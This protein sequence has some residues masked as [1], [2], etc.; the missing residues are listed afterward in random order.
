M[1]ADFQPRLLQ[2][3]VDFGLVLAGLYF[4]L[5]PPSVSQG[6]AFRWLGVILLGRAVFI[7]AGFYADDGPL[8]MPASIL[9]VFAWTLASL[10]LIGIIEFPYALFRRPVPLALRCVEC[11]F[12]M[13]AAPVP[14]PYSALIIR[15]N[16]L[17][18]PAIVSIALAGAELRKR[19]VDAGVTFLL[20]AIMGA[21][22]LNNILAITF[23]TVYHV[24]W[25]TTV[26][27]AGFRLLFWDLVLLVW[28]P[29]IAM[30]IH[31]ANLH[32]RD[33][34]ERLRREMEAARHV[35]HLLLPSQSI[36]V[37]G[38]EIEASYQPATEVG[39]DFFQILP[40][41]PAS[42]L[43]IMGDV[44]GKGMQAALLVSMVVG[45][46]RNRQSDRPSCVLQELNAVLLG[47]SEG[48]FTTC[49]CALFAPDGTVTLANAGHFAPYRNGEEVATPP[50]LPLGL[51]PEAE[52]EETQIKLQPGDRLLWVSD[53]VIE[54]R[55][56]KQGLLGFQRTQELAG[57]P[58]SEIARAAQAFG[59]EDDI[60]VLSITRQKARLGVAAV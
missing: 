49:C 18:I 33:E 45:A 53:G 50:G 59:Q 32:F 9:L 42:L 1:R 15:F 35:Q 46:L 48:G 30:Q 24:R 37:P 4:S 52:W 17:W 55:N 22:T 36:Q 12:A 60:T 47:M 14:I 13:F 41:S 3:L 38:F 2:L 23:T 51:T 10:C 5:L 40:V 56:G 57:Q 25:P 44:S 54:A 27:I 8:N 20:F 28:V 7:L 11:L 26:H 16:A 39:G 6:A 21:A 43:M 31:K 19:T 29:A 34:R 58:A